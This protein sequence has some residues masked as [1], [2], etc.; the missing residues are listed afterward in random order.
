MGPR[1]WKRPRKSLPTLRLQLYRS[2]YQEKNLGY[3]E[4]SEKKMFLCKKGDEI[5]RFDGTIKL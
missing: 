2:S 3:P 4:N 5:T 1:S